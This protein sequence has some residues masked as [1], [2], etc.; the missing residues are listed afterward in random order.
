[1]FAVPGWT[2]PASTLRTQTTIPRSTDQNTAT[3]IQVRNTS[4]ALKL[5]KKRKRG[6]GDSTSPRVTRDNL[7]DLWERHIE[8]T[9]RTYRGGED[10][11]TQSVK[12]KKRHRRKDG[13]RKRE[14]GKNGM[15]VASAETADVVKS[16][17]KREVSSNKRKAKNRSLQRTGDI[18]PQ[19]LAS[20]TDQMA[21]KLAPPKSNTL[22]TLTD[23]P[24]PLSTPSQ[25]LPSAASTTFI[26]PLQKAMREKLL[27]SRFR[28]L[29]QALYTTPSKTSYEL[30]RE[31]PAFF[32]EYHEG[33]RRQVNAWPENPVNGFVRWIKERGGVR[34]KRSDQGSQ[35]A[36]F[37][38][39]RK[40]RGG[41]PE[42]LRPQASASIDDKE[43][44]ALPRNT[45]SGI[46]TI[47]DLGCGEAQLAQAVSSSGSSPSKGPVSVKPLNL[48]IHSFDLAGS[49]PLITIADI[50]CLPLADSS[51]DLAIFCLAL[52]GT[53]W[54]DFIEEAWRVLRWKGECWVSEVGSRFVSLKANRVEHSVGN[55]AKS[56]AKRKK[57]KPNGDLNDGNS[58]EGVTLAEESA[59][60]SSKVT[61]VSTDVS[62][63]V[64]VL[65]RRGF[66]LIGDPELGNKMFVRM[67]FMKALA[68]TRGKGVPAQSIGRA[69]TWGKN[70]FVDKPSNG[71]S[72]II[73]EQEG[74]VLKPCV[75]KTR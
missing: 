20:A 31:N 73:V 32:I 71:E 44:E 38:K 40:G 12:P 49:S 6:A 17:D 23:L 47:A 74:K 42:V 68:P 33:F 69:Q 2:V 14:A 16:S 26:T 64:E 29:N 58:S 22:D 62:E 72:E 3:V 18:V 21:Q 5:P 15:G 30:F 55:R 75:Y 63:F 48:S 9:T 4:N 70:R 36:Q 7:A 61:Q 46:C 25:A 66:V 56:N 35:K 37:K 28:Y 53:N 51:I 43:I 13:D 50:R 45:R 57:A 41:S 59:L 60:L 34:V 11:E 54:I 24:L 67:R 19:K 65:K 27:S 8:G 1:M 39:K 52:M 10:V